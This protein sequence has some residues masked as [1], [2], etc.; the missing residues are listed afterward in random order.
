MEIFFRK[1]LLQYR[2]PG[3]PENPE[4]VEAIVN[5]IE[6]KGRNNL[7]TFD[8]AP[9]SVLLEVHS[10]NHIDAVKNNKFFDPDTPNIP[11]IYK[12]ASLSA[13]GAL[14]AAE[15]AIA[16][17]DAFALIRPPGHH[18][19]KNF[20]GGFCYFN[21]IAIAVKNVLKSVKKGCHS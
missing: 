1:E 8:H 5:F 14:A 15:S 10:Q 17:K 3:H 18:A 6:K 16:K 13:G 20:L 19:G 11:E 21:N 4:R 7:L 12:Y 2:E 9:E